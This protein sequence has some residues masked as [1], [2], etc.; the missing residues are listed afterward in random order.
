[1]SGTYQDPS[2]SQA[3]PWRQFTRRLAAWGP[4]PTVLRYVLPPL[5]AALS[6]V[7]RRV[8]LTEQLTSIPVGILAT[9]GA[10]TGLPRSCPVLAIP[11][12]E[13]WCVVG[14]AWGS[15]HHPSWAYNLRAH[16]EAELTMPDRSYRVQA[17]VATGA[18][19]DR[20]WQRAEQVYPG[21][22][23]YARRA[24]NREIMI[25]RLDRLPAT[26]SEG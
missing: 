11:D 1:M 7:G 6:R 15:T 25:F 18:E 14:S 26:A 10:R 13:G 12:Q 5:D 24:G 3:D 20:L 23:E 4:M 17:T 8:T 21:F 2:F 22:A 19:R 9:T 16:P